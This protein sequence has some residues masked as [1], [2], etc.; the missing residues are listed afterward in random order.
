[1]D[2]QQNG[3][4][5]ISES[6][7]CGVERFLKGTFDNLPVQTKVLIGL[8]TS[9]NSAST[10]TERFELPDHLWETVRF[11]NGGPLINQSEEAN[12][13]KGVTDGILLMVDHM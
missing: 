4:E 10:V 11:D 5:N 1:M 8:F 2:G 13:L 12:W 7:S 9:V 3:E 6:T